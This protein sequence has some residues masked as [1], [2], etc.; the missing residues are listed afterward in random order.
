MDKKTA[1]LIEKRHRL[2]PGGAHTYS[3]GDDQFPLNAPKVI[4]RGKG[5]YV[6]GEDGRKYLDW[7]M[8][9]RSVSL[10]HVFGQVNRAVERQMKEG[11]NFG[12]PHIKEF[13]LAQ[14]LIS[15]VP[16]VEM[17]KF[18]KNGST[19]TTA[20]V[21][22]ARAFTKRPYVAFCSD[23]P[24]FSY[25][26]WFIGSTPCDS[27]VPAEVKKLS[28]PFLYNDIKSLE[29]VFNNH[30]GKIACIIM[31]AVTSTE[32]DKNYFSRVQALCKKNGALLILDEMITGFRWDIRGAAKRYG[33][34]PDLVTY[35]KGIANGYSLAVLGG[36]RDVMELGGIE[37]KKERVFLISTTHGAET[38]SLAA[39]LETI[40]IMRDKKV[41]AHFWAYGKKL[42]NGIETIL[43][44]RGMRE[45][46]GVTGFAPNLSMTFKDSSRAPSLEY[47]TLF[48]QEMIAAGV[49]FQGYF[50]I[51]FSHGEREINATLRAVEHALEV[52]ARALKQGTTKGLLRGVAVKPVFRKFN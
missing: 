46:V 36:R 30:K 20:A 14:A 15:L 25:D 19:V 27:G 1:S 23:H 50:A 47:R 33:I 38:I 35:G 4:M 52:Y 3:K 26:D 24:F 39:A 5:A 32:P 29:K 12:R 16:C 21:K 42:K 8:G 6:W 45:Y 2:I 22:L 44:S 31:E 34:A 10:G 9:L 11:T 41:H 28:V 51:S 40:R 48:L 18:A 43:R 13:E 7:C 37:H 17:V 49:L